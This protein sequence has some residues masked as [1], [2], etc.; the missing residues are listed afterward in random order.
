MTSLQTRVRQNAP[1]HFIPVGDLTGLIYAY[2]PTVGAV[3]Q[4]STAQWAAVGP[5]AGNAG[6]SKYLSSVNGAGKGML[7]DLGKTVVSSGRTF[8]KIQLVARQSG[9]T[10]TFG[11]EG[12]GAATT[13]NTDFL[14][15]YIELGFDGQGNVTPVAQFGVL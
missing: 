7:K 13:P 3:A 1:S 5:Y 2:N 14:I 15:G 12:Q 9:A 6:G 11:V 8:R 4:F 10:S